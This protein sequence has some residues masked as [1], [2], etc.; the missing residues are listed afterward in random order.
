M[1][2][3]HSEADS[4]RAAVEISN[5]SFGWQRE[6]PVLELAG[7]SV[8]AGE[9]VFV[10]GPSGCGKSTLLGLIT[11]VLQPQRGRL[12][13]LGTAMETLRGGAR[14]RFRAE[15]MGVI[16]QMFNLMPFLPVRENVL[17]GCRFA[18]KR[19]ARAAAAEGGLDGEMRR[20]LA[21]LRLP[22]SLL[23]R[24]PT[25]LSIGQQQRVAAARALLGA[26]A[27]LIADEPT[28]ALDLGAR[29]EFLDLLLEETE[30]CAST[31]L[32]VSHDVALSARF[33]HALD[34]AAANRALPPQWASA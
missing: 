20:L 26:P 11:G 17:L 24:P 1:S 25:A 14:D 30:R 9:R 34:L 2:E 15:N 12:E 32:F 18:P 28:S 5:L 22:S 3:S 23:E 8:D 19:T 16:F 29:Q 27:L 4:P 10:Y 21:R 7:F 31:L 13:V 33:N 6:S